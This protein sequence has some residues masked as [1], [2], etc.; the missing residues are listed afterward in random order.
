M[1][2][3]QVWFLQLFINLCTKSPG[4]TDTVTFFMT[5]VSNCLHSFLTHLTNHHIVLN[6]NIS[7]TILQSL[8]HV[9]YFL[10]KKIRHEN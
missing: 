7:G 5:G 3:M 2:S 6:I 1:E 8:T 9:S 10:S 4:T